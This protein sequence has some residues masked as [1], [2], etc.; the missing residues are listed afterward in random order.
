ME[1]YKIVEDKYENGI[2]IRHIAISG[3][4]GTLIKIK[5]KVNGEIIFSNILSTYDSE[6][7]M[8]SKVVFIRYLNFNVNDLPEELY[9]MVVYNYMRYCVI[10]MNPKLIEYS[11]SIAKSITEEILEIKYTYNKNLMEYKEYSSDN[12]GVPTDSQEYSYSS[13]EISIVCY[14]LCSKFVVVDLAT[15]DKHRLEVILDE[16]L[17]AFVVLAELANNKAIIECMRELIVYFTYCKSICNK[18]QNL[19]AK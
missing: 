14:Y 11:E 15:K 13:I 1:H 10:M 16:Q 2:R 17:Q 4:L 8:M 9:H 19:I 5:N 18:K 6:E 3:C 7:A 12:A